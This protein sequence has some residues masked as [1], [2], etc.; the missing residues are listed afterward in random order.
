LEKI[1][2]DRE[3]PFKKVTLG[4]TDCN[5]GAVSNETI[6]ASKTITVPNP[7]KSLVPVL[8]FLNQFIVY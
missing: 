4:I 1:L 8:R 3:I 6:I 5:D 2:D 7:T